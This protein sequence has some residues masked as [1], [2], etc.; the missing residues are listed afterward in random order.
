MKK[1]FFIFLCLFSLNLSSQDI[2]GINRFGKLFYFT[3]SPQENEEQ[4][5]FPTS[6]TRVVLNSVEDDIIK[7][8][9]LTPNIS[10]YIGGFRFEGY[11][12]SM[13]V[14]AR[15]IKY[16]TNY[17]KDLYFLEPKLLRKPEYLDEGLPHMLFEKDSSEI[18]IKIQHNNIEGIN[19]NS[20]KSVWE[21]YSP[22]GFDVISFG[23]KCGYQKPTPVLKGK[24]IICIKNYKSFFTPFKYSRIILIDWETGKEDIL[25]G[26]GYNL[27]VSPDGKHIIYESKKNRERSKFIIYNILERK[28]VKELYV[29]QLYFI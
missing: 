5:I 10:I 22:C 27:Q 13:I 15:F 28:I 20:N 2:I 16:D 1:N 7:R 18:A 26:Q 9:N 14:K 12:D 19:I 17:I 23:E 21:N 4:M 3:I 25:I 24:K 8:M 11:I 6:N 29:K